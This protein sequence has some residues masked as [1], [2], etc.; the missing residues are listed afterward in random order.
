MQFFIII[1]IFKL[2]VLKK[3]GRKY[4]VTNVILE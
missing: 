4:T 2:N 1:I 3:C